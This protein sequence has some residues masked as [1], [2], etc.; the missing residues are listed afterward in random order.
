MSPYDLIWMAESG[1]Q[2]EGLGNRQGLYRHCLK[3]QD[4][5][6]GLAKE[7][8]RDNPWGLKTTEAGQGWGEGGVES[9]DRHFRDQSLPP[10][11]LVFQ[12]K[13]TRT[14]GFN[15]SFFLSPSCQGGKGKQTA[16]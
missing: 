9:P 16:A 12:E 2:Q 5:T 1:H 3:S 4:V 14:F 11:T 7:L 15:Y 6:P 8:G 10:C 13:V